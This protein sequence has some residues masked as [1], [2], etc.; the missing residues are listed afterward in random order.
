LLLGLFLLVVALVPFKRPLRWGVEFK[1][2]IGAVGQKLADLLYFTSA[3]A[4]PLRRMG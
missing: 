3:R 4:M 2:E 1:R